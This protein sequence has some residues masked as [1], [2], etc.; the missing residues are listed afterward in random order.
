M[1]RTRG[2][3]AL[4]KTHKKY[5]VPRSTPEE[6]EEFLKTPPPN[7]EIV[8][9]IEIYKLDG[10][11]NRKT[12]VCG[13]PRKNNLPTFVPEG[14]AN[15]HGVV[16]PREQY[17]C[18]HA[19]G[20]RTSHLGIGCCREHSFYSFAQ[21]RG[22]KFS[23]QYNLSAQFDEMVK[24]EFLSPKSMKKSKDIAVPPENALTAEVDFDYFVEKAKQDLTPEQLFDST[25]SLYE[26]EAIKLALKD[27][28]RREGV[29]VASLEQMADQILKSA[30]YQA[31]M[32]KRDKALM[33]ASHIQL[34]TKVLV[35]GLIN[36]VNETL[37]EAQAIE[38][39]KK[40]KTELVLP[41]NEVGATELL[42]RQQAAGITDRVADVADV[43][44][45]EYEDID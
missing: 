18:T 42:R 35:A 44:E 34:Q 15:P 37:G 11:G 1:P 21:F 31:Q 19:A 39:L 10:E 25:R 16:N 9:L 2:I 17:R 3:K 5:A 7:I 40:I 8:S 33:E 12:R 6:L 29:D 38:V 32:A 45:A 14:V 28:M 4:S 13:M 24:N 20:R 30:Q 23:R 43:V 22:D 36:I 27:E 41:I 26:L